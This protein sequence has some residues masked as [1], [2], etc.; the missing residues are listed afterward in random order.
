MGKYYRS[1]FIESMLRKNG[2]LKL[3]LIEAWSGIHQSITDDAI[4]R[5]RVRFNSCVDA[6]GKRFEHML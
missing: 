3:R 4:D 6:N 1:V 2:E 5:W